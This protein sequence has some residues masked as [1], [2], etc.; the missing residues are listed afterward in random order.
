MKIRLLVYLSLGLICLIRVEA[1]ETP[2]PQEI[3]KHSF[4]VMSRISFRA[5]TFESGIKAVVY[6]RT[7]PDGTVDI[8]TEYSMSQSF[9]GQIDTNWMFIMLQNRDGMWKL[10]PDAALRLDYLSKAGVAIKA[11]GPMDKLKADD[12]DYTISEDVQN[13][14]SCYLI[15]ATIKE[16]ARSRVLEDLKNNA[17]L[18]NL[19]PVSQLVDKFPVEDKY[20][21]GKMDLFMYSNESFSKNGKKFSGLEYTNVV[22][23]ITLANDLFEVPKDL[24]VRIL[25]T[26]EE[27]NEFNTVAGVD[28]P[29]FKKQPI[30]H[31]KK[32]IRA[33]I[34]FCMLMSLPLLFFLIRSRRNSDSGNPP[35]I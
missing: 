24:K 22:Q 17:M 13:G 32:I 21:I 29:H 4:D 12:Y 2:I 14:V 25:N 27:A 8:R 20:R 19:I 23:G 5:E 10:R 18:N 11:S 31:Q 9:N 35:N 26:K 6:H 33:V 7:N 28:G 3:V 30:Q 15:D 16:A 1:A 34:I